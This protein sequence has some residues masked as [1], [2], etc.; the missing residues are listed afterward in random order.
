[1]GAQGGGVPPSKQRPYDQA[2]SL[3]FKELTARRADAARFQA[4]GA[5]L[6]GAGL[7]LPVLGQAVAVDLENR[8][9]SVRGGRPVRVAW[10]V[11]TVH[12]LCATPPPEDARE[13]SFSYFQDCHTYLSV[14]GKRI[15]GR[16]L[17]TSGRSSAQFVRSAE[18]EGGT[19]L[20]RGGAGTGHDS[21]DGSASPEPASGR[22]GLPVAALGPRS[23]GPVMRAEPA[24]APAV[25]AAAVGYTFQ[26]F[27]RL[28]LA[29]LRHEGDEEIGPGAS[30]LYRAD[31][32]GILPAEDRVVA[33][34]LV[35]DALAGKPIEEVEECHEKRS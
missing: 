21:L 16:F 20:D 1:M 35:L 4:L 9:V 27:P 32:E 19:R 34:E 7:T 24:P 2:L 29:I 23:A 10:A 31:A 15:I 25:G 12:Y 8:T 3:G 18:R 14:F 33:A 26:V 11:L 6:D 5:T 28:P 13:V 22:R 30:V 17:A